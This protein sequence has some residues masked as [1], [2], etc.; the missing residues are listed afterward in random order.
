MDMSAAFDP[1][2]AEGRLCEGIC[3][4]VG[5]S[6]GL[7][8]RSLLQYRNNYH[9]KQFLFEGRMHD[10]PGTNKAKRYVHSACMNGNK[11]SVI[12]RCTVLRVPRVPIRKLASMPM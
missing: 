9:Q 1:R 5:H 2:I 6:G 12:D 3:I 8:K 7:Q 11:F 10:I 4:C